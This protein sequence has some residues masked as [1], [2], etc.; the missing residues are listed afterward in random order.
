[1]DTFLSSVYWGAALFFSVLF[2]WQVLATLFGH[3]GGGDQVDAGAHDAAGA[4]HDVAGDHAAH[5]GQ[6]AESIATFKLLSVRSLT[7]FGLLFGWA[8]VLYQ[9]AGLSQNMTILYSL[10][11]GCLGMLIVS[12][13]FY[14]FMRMTESGTRR[15]SSAIGQPATVYMDIPAGGSGQVRVLCGGSISFISA[16]VAGG[17]ALKAGTPVV[18]KRIIGPNAVE[19]EK[20][21]A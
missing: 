17:E 4:G 10:L 16:R 21:Q 20:S 12:A 6:A 9:R 15:L 2:A 8:G 1:M 11:W 14:F 5:G 3:L 7:S 18:V 19:V 13:L